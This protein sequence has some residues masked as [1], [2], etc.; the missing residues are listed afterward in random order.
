M[1]KSSPQGK[2]EREKDCFARVKPTARRR[3]VKRSL[4]AAAQSTNDIVSAVGI[5]M[6]AKITNPL[7]SK[8]PP[9]LKRTLLGLFRCSTAAAIIGSTEILYT[10]ERQIKKTLAMQLIQCNTSLRMPYLIL[11]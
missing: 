8:I 11:C 7:V 9:I 2:I 10:G 3:F 4:I 5:I 6:L 1:L